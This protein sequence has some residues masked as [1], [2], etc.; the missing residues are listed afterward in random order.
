MGKFPPPR[1]NTADQALD[2]L[3][4]FIALRRNDPVAAKLF[5]DVQ[6]SGAGVIVAHLDRDATE[7]AG[8]SLFVYQLNEALTAYLAAF[9]AS[10]V[11]VEFG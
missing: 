7:I 10:K 8:K 4:A 9:R 11:V 6:D 2:D 1:P 5:E 3:S